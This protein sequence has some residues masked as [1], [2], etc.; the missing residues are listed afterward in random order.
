[1]PSENFKGSWLLVAPNFLMERILNLKQILI[2][3]PRV[4]IDE[5]IKARAF[6]DL[7]KKW[8]RKT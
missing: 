1:M 2:W 7:L 3:L 5:E 6:F 4:E 8:H